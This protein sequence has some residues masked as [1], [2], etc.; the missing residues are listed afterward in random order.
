MSTLRSNTHGVGRGVES[1]RAFRSGPDAYLA[2]ELIS[3]SI[4]PR[5]AC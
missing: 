4:F 2:S 1:R 3:D 5:R